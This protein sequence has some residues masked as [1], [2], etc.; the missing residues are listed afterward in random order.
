[1]STTTTPAPP[2]K[3]ERRRF[4]KKVGELVEVRMG[5]G[6]WI[7]MPKPKSRRGKFYVENLREVLAQLEL[8]GVPATKGNL[9]RLAAGRGP[10]LRKALA[11]IAEREGQKKN[12]A[13]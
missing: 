7:T 9:R 5:P 11:E 1:M 10:R 6:L 2:L 8:A 4:A 3:R 13:S 12:V